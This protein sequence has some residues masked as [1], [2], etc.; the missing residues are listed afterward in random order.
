MKLHLKFFILALL[1]LAAIP[2]TAQDVAFEELNFQEPSNIV[3]WLTPL[4]TLAGTWLLKKIPAV[5]GTITLIIVPIVAAG[6]TWLSSIVTGDANWTA[7]ILAGSGAVLLH[8][9]Y[10]HFKK[11]VSPI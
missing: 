3:L 8:Q 4:L 2:V 10:E 11:V 7:Q 9:F 1:F 5:S 6:I